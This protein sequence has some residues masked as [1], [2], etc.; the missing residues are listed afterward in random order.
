MAEKNTEEQAKIDN[1]KQ[2]KLKEK[3][4]DQN[5]EDDVKQMAPAELRKQLSNKNGDYIFRLQKELEVQGKMSQE[6]AAGKVD[7]L[8]ADL[9][10]AQRHG[11]PASTFYGMSPKLK[12]ADMLKPKVKTAA[13]I[14]FWQYAVDGA[15]LYITIFVG[16]FGLIA[17]FSPQA[18]K[19]GQM[20]I[21]TLVIIGAAMGIF[22]VKYNDWVLPTAGK[23]RKIPWSKLLLGMGGLVLLLLACMYLLTLP[24]FRMINPVLPGIYDVII[25]AAAYGIRWLFRRHY[26]IIGSVFNPAQKNK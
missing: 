19:N 25:A 9:V 3:V 20:G 10:V 15:L 8:L 17:L 23:D 16:L 1:N 11:Q 5:M 13:D 14:P 12:A 21:T 22:M 4:A 7:A 2:E 24:I 6:D 18:T 26:Q